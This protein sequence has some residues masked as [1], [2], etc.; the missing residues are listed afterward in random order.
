MCDVCV[1]I[2]IGWLEWLVKEG[3]RRV[4]TGVQVVPWLG[5]FSAH[6]QK[7]PQLSSSPLPSTNSYIRYV[8][9][10]S[11]ISLPPPVHD[12]TSIFHFLLSLMRRTTTQYRQQSWPARW[13]CWYREVGG[14]SGN[15]GLVARDE[16]V[17]PRLVRAN[18][19]PDGRM[20]IHCSG[21]TRIYSPRQPFPP[22]VFSWIP[23]ED[24]S[25]RASSA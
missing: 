10:T 5:V 23:S 8:Y 7:P 18:G 6:A 4:V 20:L 19:T 1:E 12:F 14:R 2:R 21:D 15:E 25:Y 13:R 16:P 17:E 22:L 24:R 3:A 9:L 11:Y